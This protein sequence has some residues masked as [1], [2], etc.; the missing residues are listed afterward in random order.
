MLQNAKQNEDRKLTD[1]A[2]LEHDEQDVEQSFQE[3]ELLRKKDW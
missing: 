3:P 1:K 2:H